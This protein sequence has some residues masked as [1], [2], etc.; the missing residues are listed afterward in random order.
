[1]VN[2]PLFFPVYSSKKKGSMLFLK[3]H[4]KITALLLHFNQLCF[5]MCLTLYTNHISN[6]ILPEA[7]N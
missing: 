5:Q 7:L 6:N 3:P 1:M 2:D 4:R